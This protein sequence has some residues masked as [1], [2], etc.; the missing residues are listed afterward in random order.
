[1][2]RLA[3]SSLSNRM[4]LERELLAEGSR[5]SG[6]LSVN[7]AMNKCPLDDEATPTL[8]EDGFGF[9]FFGRALRYFKSAIG[10]FPSLSLSCRLSLYEPF[11]TLEP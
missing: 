1:M 7:S 11:R 3:S 6:T 2:N 10:R 5:K 8:V 4:N 9:I